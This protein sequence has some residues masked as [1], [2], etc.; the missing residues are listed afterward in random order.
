MCY[1]SFTNVAHRAAFDKAGDLGAGHVEFD[2][3]FNADGMTVD[4]PDRLA[5]YLNFRQA[6]RPFSVI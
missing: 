6:W 4:F 3:H 1:P 2:V 5:S